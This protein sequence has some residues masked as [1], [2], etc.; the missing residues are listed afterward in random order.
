MEPSCLEIPPLNITLNFPNRGTYV[1]CSNHPPLDFC[2]IGTYANDFRILS[3]EN[4]SIFSPILIES[5]CKWFVI[6][7]LITAQHTQESEISTPQSIKLIAVE[8]FN[9]FVGL[10]DGTV[11]RY[12]IG[13]KILF[14]F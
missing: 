8:N 7:V 13:S 9:I 1:L 14:H 5:V 2:I 12:E 11:L 6:Y 10:R 4:E 3:L